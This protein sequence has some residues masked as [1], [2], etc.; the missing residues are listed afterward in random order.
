MNYVISIFL[1][2]YLF[3]TFIEGL[4]IVKNIGLYGAILFFVI[5]LFKDRENSY[6]FYYKNNKLLLNSFFIFIFIIFLS[7]IFAYSDIKPSL[8]EFRVEF[9]NIGIFM[10]ISL[11][12][13]DRKF[14]FNIFLYSIVFAFVYNTIRYGINYFI[15]NPHLNFSIRLK[16]NYSDYFEILYPFVLGS[17][18]IIRNKLKY[19]IFII[20]L[21]GVFE[22]ILTGARGAWVNVIVETLLAL[23]L[24]SFIKKEYIKKIL[25][26]S[27]IG[28]LFISSGSLY[29]YNNSTLVKSKINQGLQPSGRDKIIKT[30]LPL[31]LEHGNLIIGVG[32]PGNYQYNKLL[33]DY[34]APRNYGYVD[35]KKFHYSADEPYL[36]Q[37]FYKEGVLGLFA[38]LFFSFIL[39]WKSIVFLRNS[40]NVSNKFFIF[41][42]ITSYFGYYFVRG[43]VEGR[44]FKYILIYLTLYL[45]IKEV[46]NVENN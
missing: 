11:Y 44:D 23:L 36:L 14:L 26:I 32:G 12:I 1:G 42:I 39:F 40:N 28:M 41:S 9:L 5:Q 25:L 31:F 37:I 29:I 8:R 46:K 6:K 2:M 15:I 30:R 4:S 17:L 16:R 45:I 38:F 33:N 13:K 10:L 43:L 7:V 35:G 34:N 18:F 22:L 19:I 21:F 3:G 27:G 20:L 24:I